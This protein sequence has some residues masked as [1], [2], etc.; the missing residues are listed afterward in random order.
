ME[1]KVYFASDFHLGVDARLSSKDREREIV[2]WLDVI[3]QDASKLYLVGDVFDYWF[4]Y[5]QVL[6][7]GFHRFIGKLIE[8]RDGGL[9]IEMF[10]GN[11]DMWM[12][13]FFEEELGIPVHRGPIDIEIQ[14][15]SVHIAHGDGLGPGDYGYKLLKSILAAPINQWLYGRLHP[16]LA[17]WLMR[18]FS[19]KSRDA[20]GE[21]PTFLG[22]DKERLVVYSEEMICREDYDYLI[23]GHRHLPLEVYLSNQRSV[24]YGLGDWL[25]YQSYGVLEN[26]VFTIDYYNLEDKT[27]QVR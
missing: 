2:R 9:S 10:T 17:L 25:H 6:P 8:L 18:R 3:A 1:G 19:F 13:G 21:E 12:F 5:R 22:R 14:G 15:K 11:H 16:N 23:F 27:I 7:R 20:N 26:G 4:E 24:Y